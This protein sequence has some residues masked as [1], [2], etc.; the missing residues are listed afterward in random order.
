MLGCR[1]PRGWPPANLVDL[2]AHFY[3]ERAWLNRMKPFD[4]TNGYP[5][6]PPRY[7]RNCQTPDTPTQ[8]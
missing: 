3:K 6:R 7:F 8:A 4:S 2:A 5:Q 1:A